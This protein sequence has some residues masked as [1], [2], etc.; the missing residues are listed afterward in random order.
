M[1]TTAKLRS[2][3]II[4]FNL[5]TTTTTKEI[6]EVVLSS[7]LITTIRTTLKTTSQPKTLLPLIFS[8]RYLTLIFFVYTVVDVSV[9][10]RLYKEEAVAMV[11]ASKN[12]SCHKTRNPETQNVPHWRLPLRVRS[13]K[14]MFAIRDNIIDKNNIKLK[15]S[16]VEFRLKCVEMHIESEKI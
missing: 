9:S 2:L 4:T 6:T 14:I 12:N 13:E 8:F 3:I 7:H 16:K 10:V 11:T 1:K 5:A 15:F